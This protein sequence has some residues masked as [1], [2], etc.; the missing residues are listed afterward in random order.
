MNGEKNSNHEIDSL[1]KDEG[2]IEKMIDFGASYTHS[3]KEDA[4][5]RKVMRSYIMNM[6]LAGKR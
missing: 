3:P 5:V 1:L 2:A 6:L 4:A